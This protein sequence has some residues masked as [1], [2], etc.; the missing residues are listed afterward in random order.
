MLHSALARS[1]LL[2]SLLFQYYVTLRIIPL[3]CEKNHV[4]RIKRH[5]GPLLL[6]KSQPFPVFQSESFVNQISKG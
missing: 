4:R 3:P 6:Q 1:A 2:L 5:F